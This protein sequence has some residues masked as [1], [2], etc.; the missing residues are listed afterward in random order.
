MVG[1]GIKTSTW[2]KVQMGLIPFTTDNSKW[3]TDLNV[4]C[5]TINIGEN[6]GDLVFG[7]DVLDTKPKASSPKEKWLS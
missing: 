5:E 4:K 7:D 2:K 3:I 1:T 6:L